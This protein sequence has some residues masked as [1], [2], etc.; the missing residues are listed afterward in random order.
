VSPVCWEIVLSVWRDDFHDN[1]DD[2]T[3]NRG[4]SSD[5]SD[6]EDSDGHSRADLPPAHFDRPHAFVVDDAPEIGHGSFLLP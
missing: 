5:S 2:E 6:Y 3:T 1:S 4:A